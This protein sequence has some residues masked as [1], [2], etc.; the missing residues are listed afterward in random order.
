LDKLSLFGFISVSAMLLFYA[1]E[2]RSPWN[3]LG[4]A[5]C[6]ALS[7]TYGFLQGA[8]PFGG[9]EAVWTLVA[10]KRWRDA[11]AA[12]LAPVRAARAL[13]APKPRRRRA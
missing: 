3:V 8:W 11:R 13:T 7:S 12:A 4:F 5:A 9:V 10:L 2:E 6:C 1:F